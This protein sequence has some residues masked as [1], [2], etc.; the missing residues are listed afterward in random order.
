M[1]IMGSAKDIVLRPISAADANKLVKKVHYSGKVTQN[2]QIHVGVFYRGKLEGAL[3]FGPSIDKRKTQ[4]LVKD[5]PWNGFIELNRM[6]FSD[7]LPRNSE[8]RALGIAL[9]ML[10]AH[11]PQLEWVISYSDAT[12]CG[13][14]TIYRASGF[15]LTGIKKNTTMLKM[16]SGEIVAD[17]TLN[18]HPVK[19]AS[20]WKKRGAQPLVGFQLRYIY[21]LQPEARNR[22]T[23]PLLPFAEIDRQGARMYLGKRLQAS[24]GEESSR[25]ATSGKKGGASPTLT[26]QPAEEV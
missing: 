7:S 23:V 24:E 15:L 2:S 3:Q 19:N 11:A 8:S 17:K 26:L 4:P 22:L 13:D 16:P 18:D 20:Y 25:S 9:K 10:K 6:A 21:F 14:G 12:Q 1:Q 5:T